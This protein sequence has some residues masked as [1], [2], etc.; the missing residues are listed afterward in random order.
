MKDL[1]KFSGPRFVLATLAAI[2]LAGSIR[3]QDEG[4]EYAYLGVY[5]ES[6]PEILG[7]HLGLQPG[8][9]VVVEGVIEGG[10]AEAAGLNKNDLLLRFDD[11]ILIGTKQTVTLVRISE[12]GSEHVFSIMRKGEKLDLTV[13]LGA[14][15]KAKEKKKSLDQSS[16]APVPPVPPVFPGLPKAAHEHAIRSLKGMGDDGERFV[17]V[18]EDGEIDIE[19]S[20]ELS[21]D[22]ETMIERVQLAT[23]D[24]SGISAPTIVLQGDERVFEFVDD[25]GASY[26]LVDTDGESR[27]TIVDAKGKIEFEGPSTD[28]AL[29]MLPEDLRKELPRIQKLARIEKKDAPVWI[30]ETPSEESF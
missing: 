22:M 8:V 28:D 29:A 18:S 3:A 23:A 13:K 21:E 4:E 30:S 25:T 16:V 24:V 26:T 27:L 6:I 14:K 1:G 12:P 17:F 7:E 10:P 20:M 5:V 11:Q 19:R 2:C 9:G 15:K